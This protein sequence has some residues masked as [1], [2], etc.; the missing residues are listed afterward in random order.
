MNVKI[1]YN[2]IRKMRDKDRVCGNV[3]HILFHLFIF[4][5]CSFYAGTFLH[6]FVE[7]SAQ[8]K[9]NRI[10]FEGL[11]ERRI[12]IRE[13]IKINL[14]ILNKLLSLEITINLN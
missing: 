10:N 2:K 5:C 3:K 14:L 8:R 11:C 7:H 12:V 13:T 6:S 4:S 1:K 9:Q